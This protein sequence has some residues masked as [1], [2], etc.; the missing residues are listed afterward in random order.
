ICEL[1]TSSSPL[2]WPAISSP[3]LS[4]PVS[5]NSRR[6]LVGGE[7]CHVEVITESQIF[8]PKPCLFLL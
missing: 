4:S 6:G 1:G 2:P 8:V 7:W 3:L 5:S